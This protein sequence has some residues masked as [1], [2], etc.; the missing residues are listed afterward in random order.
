MRPMEGLVGVVL[1]GGRSSRMGR[2][3][4]TLEVAG[5]T[6]AARAYE[7]L[8]LACGEVMVADGGRGVVPEARSVADGPGRG[9]AAGLLGAARAVPGRAL[10]ALACDVP[11]V[12][13][14]LLAALAGSPE[15]PGWA[16][17]D[18]LVPRGPRGPEPLVGRYGP[19]AL[20]ALAEQVAAGD[21]SVRSLFGRGE[22][23]VAFVEGEEL[24]RFGDPERFLANVNTPEELARLVE[25]EGG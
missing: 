13:G 14:A 3:K 21:Y 7:R 2:D 25:G 10:L 22:L 15:R 11:A 12:P 1:A 5:R 23:R 16:E 9:P 4:A 6:L 20:A 8:G 24:A 17:A 18:V 19:R